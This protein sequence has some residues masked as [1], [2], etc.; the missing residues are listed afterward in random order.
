M[1]Q[2]FARN[3]RNARRTAKISQ[4][5]LYQKTGLSQSH[6]SEVERCLSNPTLEVMAILA[7]GVGIP[8]HI[9]LQP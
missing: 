9:L 2:V 7:D 6:I 5:G 8:L 4:R 1:R 3:L